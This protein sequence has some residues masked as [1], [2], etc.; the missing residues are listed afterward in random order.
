MSSEGVGAGGGAGARAPQPHKLK[1]MFAFLVL[2]A[3][4]LTGVLAM[5]AL[6]ANEMVPVHDSTPAAESVPELAVVAC[7]DSGP[8]LALADSGQRMLVTGRSAD[9]AWFRV[10][11]P[12][13]VG[14][15]GWAPAPA[16]TVD[17]DS[18]TL[19]IVACGSEPTASASP[20]ATATP[21]ASPTPSPTPP[22]QLPATP[23]PTP[24]PTPRPAPTATPTP[25][26]TRPPP[27]ATPTP[28][29]RPT[30]TRNPSSV[31]PPS[32]PT[33]APALGASRYG[34]R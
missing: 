19:P 17:G 26:P 6:I 16:L 24:T 34:S 4:G 30:P 10:H 15:H 8:V 5:S 28:T 32:T 20:T 27:T 9:G 2:A 18:E 25:L 29:P 33:P 22:P 11:V 21:T 31:I 12:G 3:G 7:P 13:P 14:Q 23:A 1:P